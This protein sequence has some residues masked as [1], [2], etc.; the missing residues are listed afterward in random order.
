MSISMIAKSRLEHL[1]PLLH[2]EGSLAHLPTGWVT[3]QGEDW[4]GSKAE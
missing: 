4:M 1:P 2:E 3:T